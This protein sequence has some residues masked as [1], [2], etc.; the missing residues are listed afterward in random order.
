MESPISHAPPS[1]DAYASSWDGDKRAASKNAIYDKIEALDASDNAVNLLTNT[2]F[3]AASQRTSEQI[4]T[5]PDSTTTVSGTTCTSTA[6]AL[7]KGML[8]EDGAGGTFE[9]VSITSANI[10]EVDRTGADSGSQWFEVTPGFVGANDK[11]FDGW[12]KDGALDVFRQHNDGGVLTKDGAFYSIKTVDASGSGLSVYFPSRI[13]SKAEMLQKIAGRT[14]TMGAWIK[15]STGSAGRVSF[16]DGSDVTASEYHTGGGDWEW[17]EVTATMSAS[18]SNFRARLDHNANATIYFSQPMLVFGSSIGEGNFQARPGEITNA[19]VNIALTDYTASA[20]GADATINL[21]AQ[22]SGKIGKGVK[23]VSGWI[24]GQNSAADKFVDILSESGGVRAARL[25]SQVLAKDN[26]IPFRAVTD[27]NG[28]IYVD[29]EDGN[30]TN[31]TIQI[32]AIEV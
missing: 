19:E 10:F 23:A 9:A 18:A 13:G 22:S 29:V 31:V 27:A 12:S 4:R 24:E 25:Y 1:D 16:Y 20:V 6:H 2:L 5:L 7:T 28:D 30:W 21:E 8:V 26:S 17:L 14:L 3:M 32:N 15:T 11:C